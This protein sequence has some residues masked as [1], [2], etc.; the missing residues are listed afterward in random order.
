MNILA[1]TSIPAQARRG[2]DDLNSF[3]LERDY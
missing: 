1:R 3:V 2:F